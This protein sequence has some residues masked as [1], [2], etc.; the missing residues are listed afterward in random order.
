M[1]HAKEALDF[2]KNLDDGLDLLEER[3]DE[4]PANLVS[5]S[6]EVLH[7]QIGRAQVHATLAVAAAIEA[8]LADKRERAETRATLHGMFG[9]G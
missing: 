2:I 4:L 9:P 7:I 6:L 3:G 8:H 1:D 5:A